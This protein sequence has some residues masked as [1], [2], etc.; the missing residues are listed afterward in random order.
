M[1]VTDAVNLKIGIEK[2]ALPTVGS[3]LVTPFTSICLAQTRGEVDRT[4]A[5]AMRVKRDMEQL[6]GQFAG[7]KM[8]DANEFLCRFL[9]ELKENV[10]KIY[11]ENENKLEVEE[12]AGRKHKLSNLVDNFQ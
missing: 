1:L 11:S 9:D 2:L 10:G 4:N 7:N 8:Q 5:N 3:K 6:D 12:D